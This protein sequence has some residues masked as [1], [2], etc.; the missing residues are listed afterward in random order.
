MTSVK[1]INHSSS[2]ADWNQLFRTAKHPRLLPAPRLHL[3]AA[4]VAC[5]RLLFAA[6]PVVR[7]R[8]AYSN[9]CITRS[10]LRR[11]WAVQRL[12]MLPSWVWRTS[13]VGVYS[14]LWTAMPTCL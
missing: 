11:I 7:P 4:S 3:A 10:I 5:P 9:S 14:P 1:L 12:P 13:R 2:T 6:A 8:R